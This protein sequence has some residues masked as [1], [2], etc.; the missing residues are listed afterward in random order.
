M[1][2]KLVLKTD[3]IK[4]FMNVGVK[5]GD[6][7]IVHCSMSKL[8]YVCGGAQTVIEALMECVGVDGNIVMPTQTWKNLDPQKGVHWE[9]DALYWELIRKN[10]PAD[11]KEITP[12][13]NM[14]CVAEMFRKWPNV[15]RSDHPARSFA[16]WGKDAEY[17]V[18]NHDLSNIFGENSPLHKIY[19]LK[20]KILLVGVGYDKCTSLHLAENFASIKKEYCVE[21][22]AIIKDGKRHWV[23]YKTMDVDDSDFCKLGE[24]FENKNNIVCKIVEDAEIRCI[25]Q[26]QLV[27]FAIKWFELNR[28]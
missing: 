18:S 15:L 5:K 8:G 28:A 10:W 4:S 21:N 26:V 3:L 23:E 24:E 9:V 19:N 7:L 6:T 22:S 12:S 2:K 20:G 1:G 14:G 25:D 27:D 13:N 16:A 11:D 17:I